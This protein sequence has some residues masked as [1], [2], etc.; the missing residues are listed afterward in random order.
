MES[1]NLV[2][3]EVTESPKVE[4]EARSKQDEQQQQQQQQPEEEQQKE[5]KETEAAEKS[6][7]SSTKPELGEAA[8]STCCQIN[9]L[10]M[11]C[12]YTCVKTVFI[13]TMH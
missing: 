8:G 10:K 4:S 3:V 5:E 13:L 2:I 6:V 12:M 11:G 7:V 9:P 1:P